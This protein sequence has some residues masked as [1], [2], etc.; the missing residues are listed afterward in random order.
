MNPPPPYT[1]IVESY[2]FD[3]GGSADRFRRVIELAREMTARDG[4]DLIVIDTG[5]LSAA[6]PLD[7]VRVLDATGK[8]YD[9]AKTRAVEAASG[10]YVLFL[11][12][13]CVPEPGWKD[14]LLG[15]LRSGA[16]PAVAGF[17]RYDGGF[18]AAFE[19]ILD[20]GFFFPVRRRALACYAFNNIG[21]VRRDFLST[22]VPSKSLRCSCFGHAQLYMR[23][24]TPVILCPEARV[25]HERQPWVRERT[26]QG[27]DM[28][29][30]GWDGAGAT[31][32]RLVRFGYPAIPMFFLLALWRD[33]LR[34]LVARTALGLSWLQWLLLFP[35]FPAARLLD[36]VGVLHALREGP[37][38]GG[39]GGSGLKTRGAGASGPGLASRFSVSQP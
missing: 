15:E 30:A 24:G 25:R 12:G 35:M 9:E 1:L 33:G 39:W 34:A 28:V 7:G 26:R 2:T 29:A 11:D 20:F 5:A 19:T 36:M 14:A 8:G 4:G 37:R 13:D 10:E 3:E 16:G 17:T 23:L 38:E 18:L 32:T 6:P 21:F 27:Y 31:E 22:Q